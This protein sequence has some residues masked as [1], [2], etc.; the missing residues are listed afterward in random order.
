MEFRRPQWENFSG[1]RDKKFI[2]SASLVDVDEA[3]LPYQ[4]NLPLQNNA[5]RDLS[6]KVKGVDCRDKSSALG[7]PLASTLR[8]SQRKL[9]VLH[10]PRQRF[11]SSTQ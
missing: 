10:R 3:Q 5:Q 11:L 4:E 2:L 8:P 1:V 7:T 6:A 9:E